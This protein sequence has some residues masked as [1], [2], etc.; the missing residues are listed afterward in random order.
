MKACQQESGKKSFFFFEKCEN[1]KVGNNGR[2][3]SQN[4]EIFKVKLCSN[5]KQAR[6]RQTNKKYTCTEL[7]LFV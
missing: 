2:L 6:L 3:S 7:L 4:N 1:K 5:L